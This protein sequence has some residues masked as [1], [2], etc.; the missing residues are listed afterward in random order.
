MYVAAIDQGTTSTRCLI[1]DHDG[2][3]VA[4]HQLEHRQ[5]FPRAGWV[6]HDALEIWKNTREVCAGALARAD[7][8]AHDVAAVG[9]TNQRETA[10]VWD[11]AT[12]RPIHPAI[13]WQD[14]RTDA[15]CRRL[16]DLGGGADRYRER[17]GLPLATYFSAPKV[18]WILDHVDG[19]RERAESGEL[20]FGTIDS[21][22]VWNMTGGPDGGRHV[23]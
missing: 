15:I 5:S 16:G 2:R 11:R 7:L 6:E 1:I 9:I 10:L 21:W 8:T 19:A 23:T 12:G 17:V 22:L 4:G 14:T 20:A 18:A 3:V 13:V